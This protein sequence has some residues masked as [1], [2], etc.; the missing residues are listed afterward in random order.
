MANY[1]EYH[2]CTGVY[3]NNGLTQYDVSLTKDTINSLERHFKVRHFRPHERHIKQYVIGDLYQDVYI[4]VSCNKISEIK[5]YV[6]SVV[7]VDAQDEKIVSISYQKNKQAVHTVPCCANGVDTVRY[8]KRSVFKINNRIFLNIDMVKE[9]K[10]V[11][12][13]SY[14]NINK[15]PNS[16]TDY[17]M[18]EV[19]THLRDIRRIIT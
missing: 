12:S 6:R 3:T 7:D 13:R 18:A 19:G 14:I 9:G 1:I 17:L 4:D 10:Q 16:D 15:D 2:V 8:I 11:Y 5:S